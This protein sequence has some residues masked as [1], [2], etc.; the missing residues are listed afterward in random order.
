M[1]LVGGGVRHDPKKRPFIISVGLHLVLVLSLFFSIK[2]TDKWASSVPAAPQPIVEA[3]MVDAQTLKKE[4][5]RLEKIEKEKA[6]RERAKQQELARKEKAAV[7]KRRQEEQLL[8][9]LKRKNELLKQEAEAQRVAALKREQEEKQE[10]AEKLAKAAQEAREEQRKQEQ[11]KQEQREKEQRAIKE[12]AERE[13]EQRAKQQI[14]ARARDEYR[15][16]VKSVLHQNWTKPTGFVLTG[17]SCVVL[18]DLLPTGEVVRVTITQS[19]GNVTF[20]RSTEVAVYKSSPLP[21]PGDPG[22][23]SEARQFEFTFNPEAT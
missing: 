6:A 16:L 9:E 13:A 21:M 11:R 23:A 5:Q 19:S 12:A 22:L 18:V 2:N 7:E 4:V 15:A 20:D 17:L 10:R 1:M 14:S 3:V 8:A